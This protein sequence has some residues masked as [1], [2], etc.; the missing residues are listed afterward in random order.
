[1]GKG[2][3]RKVVEL[4]GREIVLEL[5]PNGVFTASDERGGR[6]LTR[7][8]ASFAQIY[9]D[10]YEPGKSPGFNDIEL[11]RLGKSLSRMYYESPGWEKRVTMAYSEPEETC[12][13][14]RQRVKKMGL[15]TQQ[16]AEFELLRGRVRELEGAFENEVMRIN[17][18]LGGSLR[19]TIAPWV[20]DVVV[21]ILRLKKDERGLELMGKTLEDE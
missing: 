13:E 16:E 7:G 20:D 9:W 19:R 6:E 5:Y 18:A 15:S 10:P 17:A 3:K 21:A 11:D 12:D 14:R 8:R 4:M 1:M 2:I